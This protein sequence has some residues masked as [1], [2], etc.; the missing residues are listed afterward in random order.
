[1]VPLKARSTFL[2]IARSPLSTFVVGVALPLVASLATWRR[3][4]RFSLISFATIEFR[5]V[6]SSLPSA[7][8]RR[9]RFFEPG[10]RPRRRG[11]FD[12][13]SSG[14]IFSPTQL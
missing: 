14:A 11:A 3:S 4:V 9:V 8:V 1:L 5:R 12:C 6:T 13:A 7:R 10:G 2:E